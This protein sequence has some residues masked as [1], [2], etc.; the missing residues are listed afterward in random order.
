MPF[1]AKTSANYMVARLA[2]FEGKSRGYEDMILLNNSGRVAEAISACLLLVR[3][4][5]VYAPPASEGALESITLGILTELAGEEGIPM[6]RRPIDRTEL[7]IADELALTGT[8]AEIT[9]IHAIDDLSLPPES[10]V[11]DRL[12]I[13]YLAAVKGAAPHPATE[14]TVVGRSAT[15]P[16]TDARPS[17]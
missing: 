11:L 17:S 14:M 13:R 8:L 3:D 10:P 15:S 5:V 4:G 7:Y 6:E 9:P 1:R 12:K 16:A 2:R